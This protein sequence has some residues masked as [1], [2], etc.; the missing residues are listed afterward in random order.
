[1]L[2]IG[3]TR[4]PAANSPPRRPTV[5][6]G[7]QRR[8][9]LAG[10]IVGEPRPGLACA[11]RPVAG[12]RT[13]SSDSGL[14]TAQERPHRQLDTVDGV[15]LQRRAIGREGRRRT[16]RRPRHA[17]DARQRPIA[18]R[19]ELRVKDRL[20]SR[21]CVRQRG[22]WRRHVGCARGAYRRQLVDWDDSPAHRHG[23]SDY[24]SHILDRRSDR[25]GRYGDHCSGHRC[26][27]GGQS[28]CCGIVGRGGRDGLDLREVGGDDRRRRL[29]FAAPDAEQ[30]GRDHSKRRGAKTSPA[31]DGERQE[32]EGRPHCGSSAGKMCRVL[33]HLFAPPPR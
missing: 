29:R 26:D 24:A 13:R 15:G 11:E 22:R 21:Q 14:L 25:S 19:R 28:V 16:G 1:M 18:E 27:R 2:A 8:G 12:E 30:S 31:D 23:N 17:S 3:W 10:K 32:A 5:V 4:T 6:A 9:D 20:G 7:P 33:S